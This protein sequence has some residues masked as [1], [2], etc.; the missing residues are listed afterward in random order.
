MLSSPLHCMRKLLVPKRTGC[1]S[2]AVAVAMGLL[3]IHAALAIISLRQQSVT[4]DEYNHLPAGLVYWRTGSFDSYRVNPPFAKMLAAIPV[5]MAKPDLNA[6]PTGR[7]FELGRSFMVQNKS[8]YFELYFLGRYAIVGLSVLAGSFVFLWGRALFGDWAG[9]VGLTLWAFDPTVLANAGVVTAD[10]AAAALAV[11]ATYL[12]WRWLEVPTWRGTLVVGLLLGVAEL[13][14]FTLLLLYPIW[15]ILWLA[16]PSLRDLTKPAQPGAELNAAEGG[17]RRH[18]P[19]PGWQAALATDARRPRS[20][21]MLTIAVLSLLVINA[22]YGLEGTGRHLG[23][24]EF[25]SLALRKEHIRSDV[26]FR[27]DDGN[28]TRRYKKV[29]ENRFRGTWLAAL[30]IPLPAA[31]VS[32]IDE[33]AHDFD[34][35]S[36][37]LSYLHGER[38]RGGW[39]YYYVYALAIKLSLGTMALIVLAFALPWLCPQLRT[40]WSRELTLTLPPLAM[41]TFVSSQT[42]FNAHMRYILPA[43]P[44][45]FILAGR[46]GKVFS[47]KPQLGVCTHAGCGFAVGLAKV[48]VVVC[49]GISVV[50]TIRIHPHYLSYFNELV[51]GP[52]NGQ[53][54]LLGSNL[55]WGQDLLFFKQWLREHPNARP[56]YLAYGGTVDPDVAGIDLPLVPF[57][58][59]AAGAANQP[60]DTV[61]PQAGWYAISV[62]E[63][64][65]MLPFAWGG[66]KAWALVPADAYDYLLHFQPVAKAGYSIFIFKISVDKANEVRR[67]LGLPALDD[68]MDN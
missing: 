22:G 13:S 41:L 3:G 44:F 24:F 47:L 49:L 55:D 23:E 31:Y 59:N 28:L 36:P 65:G 19:V 32:G 66:T 26:L 54:Y 40:T 60:A 4:W 14:K 30:P 15:G 45:L 62:N 43:L 20:A 6:G 50:S 52:D 38:R 2:L 34:S 10:M 67:E 53:K 58:P 61:G 9:I 63:L 48:I 8:R 21:Q 56:I 7:D 29:T 51:G 27:N 1:R 33:Q 68:R 46:S 42:A 39:W 16:W 64:Y 5:L 17:N 25:V 57:G 37:Y 12:F 35:D 18:L 11:S